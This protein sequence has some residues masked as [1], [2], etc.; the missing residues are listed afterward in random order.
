MAHSKN[1]YR[2]Q[3]LQTR[4]SLSHEVWQEDSQRLCKQIASLP[5]YQQANTILG[6]FSFRQELDLSYLFRDTSIYWGFPRCV[7][8]ALIWHRW[9]WG[10][11]LEVDGYG[12]SQPVKQAPMMELWEVDVVL[13]PCVAC[14][15]RGFRLG[16]GGGF[17]D[18]LFA[19]PSWPHP[20]TIGIVFDDA[21]LPQLPVD[22]WDKPLNAVCTPT[23]YWLTPLC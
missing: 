16:Y 2:K 23:N 19:S 12:I 18:R 4:R 15:R 11:A 14:D 8:E 22:P 5:I 20:F 13:V 21:F 6:Y 1:I 7:G 9:Q 3:I 17:Y 10:D